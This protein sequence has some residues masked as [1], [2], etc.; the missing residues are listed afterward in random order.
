[1][2]RE[3]FKDWLRN[4]TDLAEGTIKSYGSAIAELSNWAI[5]ET[6]LITGLYDIKH[7][8]DLIK[9]IGE[10]E[11]LDAY[12]TKNDKNNRR[13]SSAL[14]LYKQFLI[15]DNENK[16]T[17]LKDE[18]QKWMSHQ[19]QDNGRNY[20]EHTQKG[21]VRALQKACKEINNLRIENKDLFYVSS[22]RDLYE[23]E[24][25]IRANKDF[26]RVNKKFGKGQLSAGIIKY[27]EFLQNIEKDEVSNDIPFNNEILNDTVITDDS[28]Y[29][30]SDFLSE[31]FI[32]DDDYEKMISLLK[33]KMNLII[34]GAPG[35]G[36]TFI[37]ERLAYALIGEKDRSRITMV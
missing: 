2:K 21:Y 33:R 24:R 25:I 6:Y 15:S 12:K 36:K 29:T 13:W 35:V 31:V 1:M 5:K 26:S 10:L 32:D 11:I 22:L 17:Y 19:V 8:E 18:F 16:A 3:I 7:I 9:V 20:S 34:Q 28:C 37:A 30:K 4:N 14:V 27:T 23:I